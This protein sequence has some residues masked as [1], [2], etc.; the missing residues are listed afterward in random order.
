MGYRWSLAKCGGLITK[1]LISYDL[2]D[3]SDTEECFGWG[4]TQKF[5][6]VYRTMD[7]SYYSLAIVGLKKVNRNL[8]AVIKQ[9][10]TLCFRRR[11]TTREGQTASLVT[12]KEVLIS[13]SLGKQKQLEYQM[14]NLIVKKLQKIEAKDR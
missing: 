11:E 14:Q 1:T 9:V 7:S 12:S 3:H 6:S 8:T 13:L 4:K 5:V 10:K 2:G